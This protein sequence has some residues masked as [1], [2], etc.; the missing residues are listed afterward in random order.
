MRQQTIRHRHSCLPRVGPLPSGRARPSGFL[1]RLGVALIL[2]SLCLLGGVAPAAAHPPLPESLRRLES[3][4]AADPDNAEFHLVYAQHLRAAGQSQRAEDEFRRC[5]ALRPEW[6]AWVEAV[7]TGSPPPHSPADRRGVPLAAGSSDPVTP[8]TSPRVTRG[9]Y[10]QS[11]SPWAMTLRWRTDVPVGSRIQFGDAPGAWTGA[12]EDTLPR[13]DHELRIAG[14][15]PDHRYYYAVG[16]PGGDL[17]G[18]DASHTFVTPPPPGTR[19]PL[20]LWVIGDSGA[21]LIGS[22]QVRDGY[23]TFN[24]AL[25]ADFWLMLGDNAYNTGTDAEYQ[26]AVFDTFPTLLR[27]SVVW[28]VH[29]NHDIVRPGE[30]NDYYDF[31]TL[32]TAGEAGG[33]PSGSEAYYS[34]DHANVHVICLDS[35]DVN[36]TPSG[37][38]LTWL[39]QDLA[40]TSQQWI[41]ACWHHPPYSKGSHDSDTDTGGKQKE[42]RENALPI[43]EA[44]GVDLVLTGHSH[45]YERSF[46]LDG[47]YGLSTTLTAAMKKD[48]GDGRLLGDG[49]Y[50]KPIAV[51]A[52]HEGT[53]YAVVGSSSQTGGGPLNHPVMISS[54][55]LLGSLALDIDGLV[56]DGRFINTAGAVLDNFRIVKGGPSGT[57]LPTERP[58]A[59]HCAPNPFGS[60]TRI[61]W[62]QPQSG[63]VE[64]RVF[65]VLG[66]LVAE[67]LDAVQPAGEHAVEWQ[68]ADARNRAAAPGTYLLVVRF[69]GRV[70]AR[71]VVRRAG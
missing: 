16:H 2:A 41:V 69:E 6:S 60:T 59:V 66:R 12:R 24:G 53:V 34:F 52:P 42:M 56:L 50:V 29:G 8:A 64:I 31:F 44:A 68:G 11:G 5:L 43:L 70:T 55:N 62:T 28:P 15:L 33:V 51:R 23:A 13:L 27:R 61:S 17:A 20:R 54:L 65:D 49:A 25:D 57:P 45:S 48:D 30:T 47:H 35:Q 10:L 18:G 63:R 32:P 38:M 14:L 36:R 7:R 39:V 21:P 58:L 19:K 40:A 4:L 22:H 26:A 37:A 46:L 71:K 67:V 1:A 9:P 3:E